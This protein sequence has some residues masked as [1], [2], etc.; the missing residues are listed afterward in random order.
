MSLA[1]PA[2]GIRRL[3]RGRWLA[4]RTAVMIG[5]AVRRPAEE[6]VAG[7]TRSMRPRWCPSGLRCSEQDA[8]RVVSTGSAYQ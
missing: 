3:F 4:E 8:R 5:L 6:Y 1:R 2:D 7:W